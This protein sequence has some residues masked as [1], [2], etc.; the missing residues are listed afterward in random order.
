MAAKAAGKL[1]RVFK[2]DSVNFTR[3]WRQVC[4]RRED[5]VLDVEKEVAKIIAEPIPCNS[6][7]AS[8][9]SMETESEARMLV[10]MKITMPLTYN[11]FLPWMSANLPAGNNITTELNKNEVGIQLTSMAFAC[12]AEA[13]VGVATLTEELVTEFRK[14]VRQML[15]STS[16][17]A[18]GVFA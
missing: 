14:L 3:D 6:R 16:H 13:I 9:I 2:T 4:D 11:F 17:L 15:T 5:S 12:N 8:S 7:I 1:I 10:I 18:D